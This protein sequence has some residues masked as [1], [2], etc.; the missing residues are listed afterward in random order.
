MDNLD[1]KYLKVLLNIYST[2]NTYHTAE[3]M[4]LSQPSVARTLEKC[5]QA[6]NDPLSV[7]S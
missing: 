2:C 4:D 5:R 6:L 1:V 7:S 3:Q